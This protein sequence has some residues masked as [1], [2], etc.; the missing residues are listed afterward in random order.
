MLFD[1]PLLRRLRRACGG[2]CRT[3]P[4]WAAR[5]TCHREV[6]LIL[7]IFYAIG[8]A[9]VY[10]F[11]LRIDA[12][13]AGWPQAAPLWPVRWLDLVPVEPA[14][15]ALFLALFAAGTVCIVAPALR[16]PRIVFALGVLQMAALANGEGAINHGYHEFFW[17]SALFCLM[18]AGARIR[19][20][21]RA[22]REQAILVFASAAVLILFFYSLSGAYKVWNATVSLFDWRL[23]GFHPEALAQVL[24]HRSLHTNTD[25]PLAWLVIAYPVLGWPMQLAV[26]YFELFAICAA[27]RPRLLA[28][29]GVALIVFH[30]GTYVFLEIAFTLHVIWNA[31]FLVLAP[32]AIRWARPG[33]VLADLPLFGAVFRRRPRAV[34]AVSDRGA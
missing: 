11:A 34:P 19:S 18:P 8:L 1:S 25:P 22:F 9:Q 12:I 7:R 29:W 20:G 26:Y 24:A 15:D 13:A 5:E 16:L 3:A 23:S 14:L 31:L 4:D 6:W 2:P 30:L 10:G 17:L 28:V 33:E 21:D 27:F 32:Q